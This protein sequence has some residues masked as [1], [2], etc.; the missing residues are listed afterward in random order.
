MSHSDRVGW[1]FLRRLLRPDADEILRDLTV[2]QHI[3]PHQPI[4]GV[5]SVAATA[6]GFCPR[7]ADQAVAWLGIDPAAAVGRLRRTELSQ[8][9]R[10]IHRFW[11]QARTAAPANS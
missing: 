7:A 2:R 5:L 11:R 9:A 4:G 1:R 10:C 3:F 8:L 6:V